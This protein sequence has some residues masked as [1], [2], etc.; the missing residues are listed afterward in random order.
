M[1]FTRRT[2]TFS[3]HQLPLNLNKGPLSHNVAND[4]EH[5]RDPSEST[6]FELTSSPS[7]SV[8]SSATSQTSDSFSRL[9]IATPTDASYSDK[10]GSGQFEP[11][12]NLVRPPHQ[13]RES[14]NSFTAHSY[15][16]TSP[17]SRPSLAFGFQM[18][19]SPEEDEVVPKIEEIDDDEAFAIELANER[20]RTTGQMDVVESKDKS[21]SIPVTGPRKR[22]RPRKHPL[23]A[24]GQIKVTKGRSKT[25][26]ITC[27]R[28]KKKCDETKPTCLN[29]Q[30]NS[31]VCEGYPA[32]E[33][34]KSGR[35]KMEEGMHIRTING[36]P[37]TRNRAFNANIAMSLSGKAKLYGSRSPWPPYSDR[38]D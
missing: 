10:A 35:Q 24:P 2:S 32:K 29:C 4:G 34:W 23:P 12:F 8:E 18:I 31:V 15:V 16:S 17:T 5:A 21:V 28:R 13:R 26:C 14:R 25:G 1:L 6:R 22:G 7:S 30:K 27:R 11:V 19:S 3:T 38:R 9:A 33:I 36:I 20:I 37:F